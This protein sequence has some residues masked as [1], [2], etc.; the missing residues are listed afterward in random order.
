MTPQDQDKREKTINQMWP[1]N[2]TP[3]QLEEYAR[4][5]ANFHA[6]IRP[7]LEKIFQTSFPEFTGKI[8]GNYE[9][10]GGKL[11]IAIQTEIS[12]LSLSSE[13]KITLT[14]TILKLSDKNRTTQALSEKLNS[15]EGIEVQEENMLSYTNAVTP[16]ENHI[17]FNANADTVNSWDSLHVRGKN[18]VLIGKDGS[19]KNGGEKEQGFETHPD[20]AT[21]API[22]DSFIFQGK[23]EENE[24]KSIKTA[25]IGVK[26]NFG[27]ALK[28]V[29]IPKDKKNALVEALDF[30]AKPENRKKNQENFGRDFSTELESLKKKN[31][32]KE[33]F[34]EK[35]TDLTQ[36]LGSN[37]YINSIRGEGQENT[38]EAKKRA[39]DTAFEVSAN[40]LIDGRHDIKRDE[41]FTKTLDIVRSENS[42][43]QERYEALS[44]LY[45][46]VNT[47]EGAKEESKK[48]V[49]NR[50]TAVTQ[51][52]RFFQEEF[53]HIQEL[54]AKA[55]DTGNKQE[56]ER[57][58]IAL[59]AKKAEIAENKW[60]GDLGNFD[61]ALDGASESPTK[62]A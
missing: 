10:N 15:P 24:A 34:T 14:Q 25:L 31:G 35:D 36:L 2:E 9:K 38:V 7:S 22:I 52:M 8:A 54:L 6:E 5:R 59:E 55:R 45:D 40:S 20:D 60:D 49:R 62:S 41:N 43:F 16:M 46:I 26:E 28:S 44:K 11:D 17:N 27:D 18:I 58:R 4:L 23:L 61:I 19:E 47:S 57:Q 48:D 39:I 33:E 50:D 32:E 51:K 29:N 13:E 3:E 56:Q 12:Q 21:Y 37:Y 42:T 1:G 30:L 53:D